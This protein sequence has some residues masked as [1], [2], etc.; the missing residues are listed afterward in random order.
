MSQRAPDVLQF[1]SHQLQAYVSNS[2][3]SAVRRKAAAANGLVG[4]AEFFQRLVLM[5][6]FARGTQPRVRL[7]WVLLTWFGLLTSGQL[8]Q[9]SPTPSPSLSSWSRLGTFWQL[10]RM[11]FIPAREQCF[12]ESGE[13]HRKVWSTD[14]QGLLPSGQHAGSGICPGHPWGAP[15]LP[16]VICHVCMLSHV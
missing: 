1:P 3:T 13:R 7:P 12:P 2:I 11:F 8:S 9:A 4:S 14:S 10:S 6:I 5:C 16:A 15:P